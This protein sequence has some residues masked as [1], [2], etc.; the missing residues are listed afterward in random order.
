MNRE[1]QR[2]NGSTTITLKRITQ[3]NLELILNLQ[4]KPQQKTLVA[5]NCKSIAEAHFDRAA[6]YRAIYLGNN[7][8]GFVML[9][10]TTLKYK[11]IIPNNPVMYLWRFMIDG[12][13]QGKGYGKRAMELIIEYSKSRPNVRD[14]ILHHE[15]GKGNAGDFYKKLGFEHTG[16]VLSGELE[17]KLKLE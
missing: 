15:P 16:N 3:R 17:M 14:I 4:V 5:S 11:T 7:P 1:N 12:K 9:R 6:W 10:D 2:E 13:H 8:I